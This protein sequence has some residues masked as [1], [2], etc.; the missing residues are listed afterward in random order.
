MPDPIKVRFGRT[1]RRLRK[2][3]GIGY[4]ELTFR[5]GIATGSLSEIE[6][7]RKNVRLDTAQMLADGLGMRLSEL[8]QQAE[9]T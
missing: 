9:A 3:R 7:G 4:E 2:E 6:R 1:V 8:F 5:A